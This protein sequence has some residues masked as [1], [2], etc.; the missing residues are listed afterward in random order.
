MMNYHFIIRLHHDF[1]RM[2]IYR[3]DLKSNTVLGI[4]VQEFLCIKIGIII[5]KYKYKICYCFITTKLNWQDF[6]QWRLVKRE[7]I[8]SSE[9]NTKEQQVPLVPGQFPE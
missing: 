3:V 9:T 7:G 4:D 8:S 1:V 2:K 5:E 6:L